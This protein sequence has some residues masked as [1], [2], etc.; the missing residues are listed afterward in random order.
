[1][2]EEQKSSGEAIKNCASCKKPMKRVHRYYRNGA[3]Y[4]NKNCY[5]K[6]TGAAEPAAA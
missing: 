2:A 3:Y 6:K 1:M 5:K 4:C